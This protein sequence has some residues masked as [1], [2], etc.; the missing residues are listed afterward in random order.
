MKK[1]LGR[2][3]NKTEQ[4]QEQRQKQNFPDPEEAK[5]EHLQKVECGSSL[6]FLNNNISYSI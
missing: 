1:L 4:E 2:L 3:K 5:Q 6:I